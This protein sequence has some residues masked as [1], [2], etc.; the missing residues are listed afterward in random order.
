MVQWPDEEWHNQ[1]VAGKELPSKFSPAM[2]PKLEA[3]MAMLPGPVPGNGEWEYTLGTEKPK[4][5]VAG[6]E[7]PKKAIQ[8]N[9][10]VSGKSMT[11]GTPALDEAIRPKRSGRKRRYDEHSFEGYG[12]GFVDD[13]GDI[14]GGGGYSS[15]EGSRRS[16]MSKKKRKKVTILASTF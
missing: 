10:K 5:V 9:T 15:G 12:E 11:V 13:D 7:H 1:K 2:K 4:P 3:A 16:S 14:D 6:T 8:Q